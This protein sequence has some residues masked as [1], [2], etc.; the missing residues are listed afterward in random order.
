MKRDLHMTGAF[1]EALKSTDKSRWIKMADFIH[2]A[3]KQGTQLT[4]EEANYYIK[5]KSGHIFKLIEE[6][7]YQHN[8]YLYLC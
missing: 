7:R 2:A 6:G 5:S 8:T 4:P 3:T 1:I